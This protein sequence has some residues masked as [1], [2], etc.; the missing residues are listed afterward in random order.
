MAEGSRRT[1]IVALSANLVIAVAKL[2]A[3]TIGHSSAMLSEGAHSVADTVNEVLLLTALRRSARPADREHPFGYGMERYF[4]SLLA[5][6]GIFISGAVFSMY[7]GISGLLSGGGSEGGLALSLIVLGIGALA[8]GTSWFIAVRQL[9]GEAERRRRSLRGHVRR[10]S[11][12]SVKTVFFEDSAALIGLALAAAGVILR[13]VTGSRYPDAAAAI[14]IGVLLI[15]VAYRLGSDTRELL[16][17]R[18]ADPELRSALWQQLARAEHV[19]AVVE[20]LTM[21]LGPSEVLVAARLDLIDGLD[22]DAVENASERID[23]AIRAEHPE[24]TQVFIDATPASRRDRD[25]S[26][27]IA[28]G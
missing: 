15:Y 12:P 19:D 3:G 20:L 16:I 7:E 9:H 1:I 13:D 4:W 21:Q 24:V 11:D 25:R 22:S 2:A 5:A 26:R 28:G 14:A 8:E 23:K 27:R 10:T 17:G 18:A 6:F